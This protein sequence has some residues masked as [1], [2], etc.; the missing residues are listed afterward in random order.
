MPL[1]Y[2]TVP[3]MS[4]PL[5]EFHLVD[6]LLHHALGG[7]PVVAELLYVEHDE[8]LPVAAEN[9]NPLLFHAVHVLPKQ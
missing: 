1:A 4:T 5:P 3:L 9:M 7:V 8:R 6:T 2:H